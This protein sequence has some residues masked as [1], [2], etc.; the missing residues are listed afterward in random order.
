MPELYTIINNHTRGK[1][2]PTERGKLADA[3]LE[4][5]VEVLDDRYQ[6]WDE[7]YKAGKRKV[8]KMLETYNLGNWVEAQD[9][10]NRFLLVLK[11]ASWTTPTRE[12]RRGVQLASTTFFLV[13]DCYGTT[14]DVIPEKCW[15]CPVKRQ[16]NTKIP[17]VW[18]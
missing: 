14:L 18:K 2:T 3:I 9:F 15:L 4:Y 6:I 13:P 11:E 12:P 8:A 16:C 1:L 17:V 10:V 7:G 5:F